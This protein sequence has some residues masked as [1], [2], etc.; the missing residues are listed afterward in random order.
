MPQPIALPCMAVSVGTG[1]KM[2]WMERSWILCPAAFEV[3]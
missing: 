3:K 2:S 1:E